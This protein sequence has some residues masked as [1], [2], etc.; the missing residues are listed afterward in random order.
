MGDEVFGGHEDWRFETEVCLEGVDGEVACMEEGSALS[1]GSCVRE[2]VVLCV[3]GK[4]VVAS[5]KWMDW[6]RGEVMSW[7]LNSW[8]R[9]Q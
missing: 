2:V 6:E 7:T 1:E 5:V 9:R 8:L 3:R 4:V